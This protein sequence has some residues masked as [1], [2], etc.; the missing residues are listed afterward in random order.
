ML[1]VESKFGQQYD[2]GYYATFTPD[3]TY[4]HSNLKSYTQTISLPYT[5]DEIK[6]IKFYSNSASTDTFRVLDVEFNPIYIGN[7]SKLYSIEFYTFSSFGNYNPMTHNTWYTLDKI[8]QSI[9]TI[10]G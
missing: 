1:S 9:N 5:V 3:R 8:W 2:F 10:N 7:N 4:P 6:L